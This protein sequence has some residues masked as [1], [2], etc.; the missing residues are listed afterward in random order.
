MQ[1]ASFVVGP[2]ETNVYAVWCPG[3]GKAIVIDPGI[4]S[5]PVYQFIKRKGLELTAIVN[6]H[7]HIDHVYGDYFFK[8]QA[9]VPLLIH[10]AD[11]PLLSLVP[12]QATSFGLDPP[13]IAEPDGFLKENDVIKVGEGEFTVIHTPGHTPGGICLYR[14]RLVPPTAEQGGEARLLP[15][16][17]EGGEADVIFVGD[18][19]FAGSIGRH[20][21]PGGSYP[22]LIE[23][24]KTK[25]LVL[26]DKTV[27]YSGHGPETTIGAEKRFNPFLS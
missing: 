13:Q 20:D 19:L 18:T 3:T 11:V 9:G 16:D 12:D 25:L 21:L 5:Q 22:Q 23:S 27:V 1:I 15:P 7:G 4:D 10:E 6:T 26:P 8:T 14:A 17:K 24:I 2:F